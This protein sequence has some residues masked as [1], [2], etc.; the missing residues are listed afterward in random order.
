MFQP[1]FDR[2]KVLN[3]ICF[4]LSITFHLTVL[5]NSSTGLRPLKVLNFDEEI[6]DTVSI[7]TKLISVKEE[8]TK[9]SS[10]KKKIQKEV[11]KEIVKKNSPDVKGE[12]KEVLKKSGTHSLLAKY[13]S[14][15][16]Q[17]VDRMKKYPKPARRL[18]H[19]GRVKVEIVIDRSGNIVSNTIVKRSYSIFLNR[20]T[21]DIFVNLKKL[22]APPKEL[23]GEPLTVTIP[24]LYELR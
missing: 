21:Q 1:V 14:Q 18:K 15:V 3:L 5:V 7:R 2:D 11:K 9:I 17:V 19:Q 8:K 6:S 13:L 10:L 23:A 20:A 12:T 22:E 4:S 24:V 16:R